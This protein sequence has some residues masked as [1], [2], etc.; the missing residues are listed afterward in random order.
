MKV[1]STQFGCYKC[2]QLGPLFTAYYCHHGVNLGVL[3]F[4]TGDILGVGKGEVHIIVLAVNS[5]STI[6]KS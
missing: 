3:I 4:Y 2:S 5:F 6:G 1:R